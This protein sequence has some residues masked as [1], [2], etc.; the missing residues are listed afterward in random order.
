M[1]NNIT[2]LVTGE[3]NSIFSEIL[4]KSLNK[5]NIKN[6]LVVIT[7]KELLKTQMKKLNLKK[8]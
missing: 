6:P 8:Y 2:I 5:I 7:C 4:I 3:P 1:R